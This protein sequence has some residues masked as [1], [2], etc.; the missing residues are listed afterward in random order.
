MF[1]K[2]AF[3]EVK[4]VFVL[5][6]MYPV[7]GYKRFFYPFAGVGVVFDEFSGAEVP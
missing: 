7:C 4:F 1:A 3:E 2:K 6:G 5:E